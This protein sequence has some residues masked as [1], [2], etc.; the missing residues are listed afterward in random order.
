MPLSLA[1]IS[2]TI[3]TELDAQTGAPADPAVQ[4]KFADALA[5]ALFKVLTQQATVQS[6]GVTLVGSPGGPLPINAL[7]GVI[8]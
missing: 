3:I 7:P 4:K 1:T 6:T 5:S 2:A 8:T